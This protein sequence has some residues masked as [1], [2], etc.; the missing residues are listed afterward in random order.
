MANTQGRSRARSPGRR[1]PAGQQQL[2]G[3]G[4][5]QRSPTEVVPGDPEQALGDPESV[6]R[7]ICLRLLTDR[8][9]SRAELAT[10]LSKRGVPDEPAGAVLDRL[11]EVGL[12]DD[13]AFARQ[14]V[15]SRHTGRGLAGRAL[16]AELR[17]KGIDDEAAGAALQTID[18]D[19][20]S[21]TARELVDRRLRALHGVPAVARLRRLTGLLAR[22]GYGSALAYR[23][24]RE[25]LADAAADDAGAAECVATLE[26]TP[27]D[28]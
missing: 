4:T 2:P 3:S 26:L 6:A 10:A 17:R 15:A 9:R 13:A 24:V 16:Q 1:R 21:A 12:I 23:V 11:T 28:A 7:T 5:G 25:A 20:E 22:K 19:D 8:A 18:A 27:H 14:W